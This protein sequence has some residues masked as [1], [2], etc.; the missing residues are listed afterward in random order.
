MRP[1]ENKVAIKELI[2]FLF[3]EKWMKKKQPSHDD[4]VCARVLPFPTDGQTKQG[5]IGFIIA[6][7]LISP[8]SFLYFFFSA[9]TK[10]N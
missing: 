7:A 8:L 1:A 6:S 10:Q 2:L 4:C 9:L 3:W 5:P